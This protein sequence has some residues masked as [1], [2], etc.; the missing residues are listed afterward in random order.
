M[1]IPS[2]LKIK[3]KYRRSFSIFL[4]F[5]ALL[6]VLLI[7][8]FS[9][10]GFWLNIYAPKI[11]FNRYF[12]ENPYDAM[13]KKN[14]V[15]DVSSTDNKVNNSY[16]IC[17]HIYIDDWKY[18]YSN[19]KVVL[20]KGNNSPKIYL[21]KYINNLIFQVNTSSDIASY[22]IKNVDINRWFHFALVVSGLDIE[23]YYN[24]KVYRSKLLSSLP[25][26]NN[27][28]IIVCP[29]EGFSGLVYDFRFYWEPLTYNEIN[30]IA[31]IKPP[32]NKKY[33]KNIS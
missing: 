15:A 16:T 23:L 17:G 24:G 8:I 1:L 27:D 33:Y 12:Y 9:L 13:L 29:E 22:T 7:I 2:Y 14:L 31:K 28:N 20:E 11:N 3:K 21:D 25:R 18:R 10:R 30:K 32:L 19:E 26:L 6:I 5:L 4:S